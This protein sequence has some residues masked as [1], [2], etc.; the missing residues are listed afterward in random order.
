MLPYYLLVFSPIVFS[1]FKVKG[2]DS[3][4]HEKRIITLF[5]VILLALLMLRAPTLG[6]DL[7]NYRYIFEKCNRAGWQEIG[8]FFSEPGWFV[9]NKLIGTVTSQFQYVIIAAALVSVLP[10]LYLYR[11]ETE[12][13]ILTISLFI[14][15]P[16]FLMPFS[17]LR[18]A[19][20]ISLAIIAYE[21]TKKRKLIPYLLIVLLAFLFHRSAFM[22]LFMYPIYHA[23]ITKKWLLFLVPAIGLIF[24][25]N[26]PIF[27]VLSVFIADLYESNVHETGAYMM[28]I[29]F[30]LFCVFSFVIPD[31]NK[32][33]DDTIGLRNFL[34]LSTVIQM[35][36]PL[37]SIAMRMGYYFIIF[38][39]LLIPKVIKNSSVRWKQVAELSKYVMV[40]FFVAYFFINAP[41][42][43]S[44][45]IFPY[46]FFWENI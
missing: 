2:V 10:I 9:F 32:L 46:H 1:L 42:T 39:P 29:L 11:K 38:I 44:L 33:D 8:N 3:E 19:I 16:T 28:I 26:Q 12:Y 25:F 37:N 7:G 4:K 6:R 45:D 15:M 34:L 23:R 22:L 21:F 31:E 17:G 14:T 43:N 5:F 27:A 41:R 24:I 20:A 13:P 18:Q 30:I 36:A 40:V 35:F